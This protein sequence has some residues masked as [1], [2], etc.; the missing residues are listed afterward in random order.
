[1][2]SCVLTSISLLNEVQNFDMNVAFLSLMISSSNLYMFVMIRW[3][4]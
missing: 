3:K 2:L 1:M 4:I